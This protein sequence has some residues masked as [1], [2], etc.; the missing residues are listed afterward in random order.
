MRIET[1]VWCVVG[2]CAFTLRPGTPVFAADEST[3]PTT[4]PAS[5][6][7]SADASSG[8]TAGT[9]AV[10]PADGA[11]VD[12]PIRFSFKGATFEQV[13]DFFS[14]TTG[15][16]V[17]WQTA[18][19]G[20]TL[21]YISPESY[22]QDEALSVL[23]II[24]Q[25]KGVMLRLDRGMLYLQKMAEMQREDVPTFVGSLPDSVRPEEVVTIVRPLNIAS[26]TVL[27]ERLGAM[28]AAYG[29]VVAVPQQNALVITETAAQ[30][31]RLAL[32]IDELDRGDPDG[33]VHIIQLRHIRATDAMGALT[34]LLGQRV[35]RYVINEKG[36]QRKIEEDTMPG[37]NITPDVRTNALIARG[38]AARIQQLRDAVLL[39]DVPA[40][41]GGRGMRSFTLSR[42]APS[43][44]IQRIQPVFAQLPAPERPIFVPVDEFA[45]LT[46]I[47]ADAQIEEVVR[48]LE[49][50]D[51]VLPGDAA[52]EDRTVRIVPVHDADAAV[53]ARTLPTLLS[54]RQQGVLSVAA[55][56]DGRSIVL[57]GPR[58]DV[59]HAA[60]IVP[61]LD[62]T[63]PGARE[64]RLV[65]LSGPDP[66]AAVARTAALFD[67][68]NT[69][70][71]T[72]TTS[73]TARLDGD[74][75]TLTLVGAR[76]PMERWLAL[77]RTVQESARAERETRQIDVRH[78][79]PSR[80][81]PRLRE[82]AG[83]LLRSV[84]EPGGVG[85]DGA[86][87][88]PPEFD[89]I[90][91]L[92]VVVVTAVPSEMSA[93]RSLVQALDRVEAVDLAFRVVSVAGVS[94]PQLLLERTEAVAER[95][96]Q[97]LG[98]DA[99]AAPQVEL[100]GLTSNVL[101]SGRAESVSLWE[102]ALAEARRLLPPSRSLEFIAVQHRRASE[103]VTPL[104]DLATR[105]ISVD[106]TRMEPQPRIEADERTNNLLV[107]AEP[108]QHEVIRRL[109]RELDA[110]EP[111]DLPPLRMLQVR[112]A[113]VNRLGD[114]LR[115]RY[116]ARPPE[117]RRADPV[118]IVP[119][120]GTST[121]VV[122]AGDAVFQEIRAFI[123][124]INRADEA[125]TER[126]TMIFALRRA[127][128]ADLASAL[129]RLYP[130]PP[131]PL[132]RAGRPLPH[133]RPPREVYVTADPGTNTLIVEAPPQ[134]RASFESLVDQLDRVELPPRAT[135]RTYRIERGDPQHIA[136]TLTDLAR[137]GVLAEQPADGSKP[138]EVLVRAETTS[139]TL[140]VAGDEVTFTQVERM[141]SDLE[142]V[143]VRRTLR[144][145][146]LATGDPREIAERAQRLYREQTEGER[147]TGPVTVEVDGAR[148]ALLVVA[149]DEAMV[150]FARIID[151]LEQA[152][153]VPPE[154]ELV[155]LEHAEAEEA[156]VFLRDLAKSH[157]ALTGLRGPEP[158]F[159]AIERT[160]SVL[161]AARRDQREIVR[162]I[163]RGIDRP[164]ARMMPPLRIMQLRT[165][166]A[167]ALASAL[168]RKYGARSPEDRAERPADISADASTNSLLVAAH[169]EIAEE[170]EGIVRQLNDADRFGSAERVIRIFSLRVARAEEL[171]R[172]LDEMFPEPP[173][174][175]DARGRPMPNLRPQREV[176]VRADSQTNSIIVDAPGARMSGFEQLVEQLDRARIA[177]ETEIRTYA[178]QHADPQQ[179]A[180]TIRSLAQ[181]G[182]LAPAAADRRTPITVTADGASRTIVVS[183]PRDV[184]ERVTRVI[185]DLD[186]RPALPMVAV[187]FFR[188]EHARAESL[189]EMLRGI[190]ATRLAQ[191]LPAGATQPEAL[192]QVTADRKT[193]TLIV[194]APTE[195]LELAELLVKQL[196]TARAAHSDT[197]V[198]VRSLTFADAAS[199]VQSVQSAL[200]G[201][202]SR[203]TGDAFDV[204]LI[205]APG[206]N[207]I[208]MVGTDG[209][210]S[211]IDA[212]IEPLDARPATDA[213]DART[214]RLA[215]ANAGEIAG[216]VQRL[217]VDQQASDPRFVLERLRRSRGQVDWIPPIR[218]EA[219]WR[220]NS[221]I[222]S[223]PATTV[224]LAESLVLTLDQADDSA[225]R[226]IRTFTPKRGDPVRLAALVRR[227]LET[228]RKGGRPSAL[229]LVAE[230]Q[231]RAVLVVGAEADVAQAMALLD[232]RD[233]EWVAPPPMAMR[234]I[235][236]EHGSAQT[237]AETIRP[238][239]V[240]PSR[241][242]QSM[243]D[244]VAAGLTVAQPS[245][246]AEPG[247]QRILIAAPEPLLPLAEQLIAGLDR[248]RVE[249]AVETRV[250]TLSRAEAE[251]V[252]PVVRSAL[253]AI[254]RT[255]P[256]APEP[257]VS[258]ETS[259]NA[260][261]VTAAPGMLE[262]IER[263][264]GRFDEGVGAID[265]PQVRTIPLTKA[266]AETVATIVKDVL[267]RPEASDAF[268]IFGRPR[269]G[270]AIDDRRSEVRVAAD[271]RLNA[272]VVS[273]PPPTL[274]MIEELVRRLD[275]D[276]RADEG[277]MVHV[278]T[279]ENADADEVL[280]A[281]TD[282]FAGAEDGGS[283]PILRSDRTSN[284]LLIRATAAQFD[285]IREVALAIDRA[286]VSASREMRLIQIDPSRADAA[287]VARAL[288]RLLG[289]GGSAVEVM[290]LEELLRRRS[291]DGAPA[292]ARGT[293][294][295]ASG[296]SDASGA[297]RGPRDVEAPSPIRLLLP[298]AGDP[299]TMLA[300][301]VRAGAMTLALDDAGDDDRAER[302]APRDPDFF[303]LSR[304]RF[305]PPAPARP[306]ARSPS[307]FAPSP[308]LPVAPSAAPDATHSGG[309]DRAD[310]DDEA[311]DETGDDGDDGGPPPP[312]PS[313]RPGARDGAAAVATPGSA[314]PPVAALPAAT[315]G[316]DRGDGA[317]LAIAVDPATNSIIIIG[318]T[319]TL[320]R[321]EA[322]ARRLE[323]QLPAPADGVRSIVLP[324]ELS[325]R[326]M[327]Q[328]LQST[329][330]RLRPAGGARGDLARRVSVFPD[331]GS[332]SLVI[333]CADRDLPL[334]ADLVGAFSRA[335]AM[336]E[337]VIKVYALRTVTAERAMRTVRGLLELDGPARRGRQAERMRPLAL[338]ILGGETEF[339]AALSPDRVQ[340]ISET[341]S[342]QLLVAAPPEAIP[343]LDRF[344]ELIDQTPS[345]TVATL[346][347]FPLRHARA[348][349]LRGTF[350][351]L[352]RAR[353]R[354]LRD[355]T[356]TR[357][358][359]P[360]FVA[361]DRTNMLLVTAS[362][363]QL[364][365]VADL[366]TRLDVDPIGEAHPLRI[367]RLTSML[368]T[369]AASLLTRTV[370][371]EDQQRRS[372]ALILGDDAAGVLLVRADPD[373]SAEIDR[374]LA[375]LDRDAASDL[376][377]RTVTLRRAD[378]GSLA[379]ALQ[380]FFDDRARIAS[381]GR[382]R[383]E[384]AR[385][386][387]IVGDQNSRT[388]VIAADD[389]DFGEIE[390]LVAQFDSVE[391]AS[392][393]TYRIFPLRHARATEISQSVSDLIDSMIW[394]QGPFFF[395]DGRM[396]GG[397]RG[398]RGAVAVQADDR[399][400]ALI[401]TGEG[402]RFDLVAQIVETLDAPATADAQRTV[403]LYRVRA[404]RAD[405]V[406]ET[407]R[408]VFTDDRA[409][410]RWWD[411]AP[412][413]QGVRISAD[414]KSGTIVVVATE[415]E[416]EDIADFIARLDEGPVLPERESAVIAVEF[417]PVREVAQSIERF[418]RERGEVTATGEAPPTIV[419]AETAGALLVAASPDT[420]ALV[421]DLVGRLDQP[422]PTGERGVEIVALRKGDPIEIGRIVREQFGGRTGG[423]LTV[424][425]DARTGSLIMSAPRRQLAAALAL[426]EQLDGRAA[427]DE[428]I[429]RTYTLTGAQATDAVRILT[430]TLSLD[431]R[432]RTTGAIVRLDDAAEPVEVRARIT[433]DR[434]SNSIVVAATSES[435][436][437]IE[438]LIRQLEDVPA[439]A[440]V[441]YRIIR[442]AHAMADDL[443]ITLR[444]IGGL[445]R[446]GMPSPSFDYNRLE[447]QLIVAAT[448]DQFEQIERIIA[449]VDVPS[450]RRRTTDFVPLRFAEADKIQA[451]LSVFY[452]PFAFEADT[453]GKRTVRIVADQATNSLVISAD[454]DEWENIRALLTRLDN[455]EYD[456]SL[457]LRVLPLLHADSRSVARAINEAFA[458]EMQAAGRARAPRQGQPAAAPREG[459]RGEGQEAQ[460]QQVLIEA[461]EWVRASAEPLTNSVVVSASRPNIR[462][463]E[464][465]VRQIDVADY[466][467][468]PPVRIIP[469]TTG[470]P[471]SIAQAIARLYAD[472]ESAGGRKALR[473]VGDRV[474][475]S[476]IVRVEESE[477]AQ[478]AALAAA[479]QE[480]TG[481]RGVGVEVMRMA[482]APAR[483]VADAIR[484]AYQ[485]KATELRT[486]LS[487]QVDAGLN[488]IVVATTPELSR[489]IR[490]TAETLDALAPGAGQAV[491]IIELQHV[492]P[493]A[494]KSFIESI[495]LDRPAPADSAARLVSEPVRVA[496]LAG[497]RAIAVVAN[498]ADRE[499]I[500]QALKAIDAEPALAEM[501][502]RIHRLRYAQASA[503]VT[504][505]QGMF[506]PADQQVQTP[507]AAAVREQVRRLSV[508]RNGLNDQDLALD[509]TTP[510]RLLADTTG[511]GVVVVSTPENVSAVIELVRLLDG[512]PITDAVA[513]QIFPLENIAAPQF[514]R[515]VRDL[516]DQGKRLARVPG[517]PLTAVPGGV[518]GRA[519]VDELA[520]TVD[521]RTNTVIAAGR[522]E[523]VAFVDVLRQ[524]LD[525][526][527]AAGWLEPRLVPLVHADA[528]TLAETLDAILVRGV[529][530]LPQSS[531][532][533][534]QIGRLRVRDGA[535]GGPVDSGLFQPMTRLVIRAEPALKAIVLVGTPAN[536]EAVGALIRMLDVE[537]AAPGALVRT[538]PIRNGSAAR[539]APIVEQI[540]A[541]QIRSRALREEDRLTVQADERTNSIIVSTSPRA[542]A[543]LEALLPTL[544]AEVPPELREL[545]TMSL[546]FASAS[547]LAAT[548][549][550]LMDARVDR[551]RR[552]RPETADLERVLVVPD[553][554]TNALVISA[555]NEAYEVIT[556]LV[557]E[558]DTATFADASGVEVIPVET[559]NVDRVA[560][561]ID[562]IMTRRYSELPPEIRTTQKPLVLVDPRTNSLL[563]AANPEDLESIRSLVAKL[564][565][566]PTD[567]AVGVHV[568]TLP[569]NANATELAPR[570]QRLMRERIQSLG[571]ARR[572]SDSITIEP[573]QRGNALIVASSRE[574]L[575]IVEGL[576]QVLIEAGAQVESGRTFDI[577]Q[578]ALNRADVI[579]DLLNEIHVRDVNEKRG[580]R[581]VQVTA[582][583][584]SNSILVS[585]PQDEIR[586]IRDLVAQLDGVKP[587][588]VVE[589]RSIPLQSANALETVG[590]VNS[591]LLGRGQGAR[592]GAGPAQV[593]RYAG[594]REDGAGDVELTSAIRDSITLTPDVR[595]NT[596]IVSAP[597][598]AM[599]MI[600]RMIR[601]LDQSSTGAKSIRVFR[602]ENADAIATR[603]ILIDLFNLRQGRELLVLKPR[604]GAA[605]PAPGAP[606]LE[607]GAPAGPAPSL[608]GGELTAVP[609]ERQQLSITVDSRTNSL[610]VSGTP[611][612]LD[613][614]SE[615]VS[616]LD[617]REANE[618]EV[619]VY[620]LRNAGAENVA[621][622]LTD[623]VQ[624]EQR[625]MVQTLSSDQLG[626]AARILEREITVRGDEKSNSVLISAS[627]RY[628]ETVKRMLMQ[629]DIDPPQVL[630]QVMLA[631]VTLDGESEYGLDMAGNFMVGASTVTGGFGFAT[632]FV[633][634]LGVPNLSV[635]NKDFSLLLRAMES[636]GRLQVLS[637]PSIMA[638]NNEPAVLQVGE[639]IRVPDRTSFTDSGNTNTITVEKELGI[640]LNVTPSINPDGFVRMTVEPRIEN[641]T[642]RTTQINENLESPVITVR[643]ASTTV[644]VHD[645]Q[646]IVIG[647]LISDRFER[648]ERKVPFLGDLPLVGLLFRSEREQ[649]T[650]TEF[651]IVLTPHVISSPSEFDRVSEL[652][653]RETD[654]LTLPERLRELI[655]EGRFDLG[656]GIFDSNGRPILL[657]G[658]PADGAPAGGGR[659]D[660]RS[661]RP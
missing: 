426:V 147:A 631:E 625:R 544:D 432:G 410:R 69:G 167:E 41:G 129:E 531:P 471:E 510:I 564:E 336:E 654:R 646:T 8:A 73:M 61:A 140:I 335:P 500:V 418:L 207:A 268:L 308:A 464:E 174:P 251:R 3:A 479:M 226:L 404:M 264:V 270:Q 591:V 519:L 484:A 88:A 459:A 379:T 633:S 160:N 478:I 143:P 428:T 338:R 285:R 374:V 247:G 472:G 63:A 504:L 595:T 403:R 360:E 148:G 312:A 413:R 16:P 489:E 34:S 331:D 133:L 388:L 27:A 434:R 180:T 344:I 121:L 198:R 145:F 58:S 618:R 616:E 211:E 659:S 451:A 396:S 177:D 183:G 76:E 45:R 553:A 40:T 608:L 457:Q 560:Q 296:R 98:A 244:V 611:A 139:R 301:L 520:L 522:E 25:S 381:S 159:E 120:S 523:A 176:V 390:R 53:V 146:E 493:D 92:R 584:R 580:A 282:L 409:Q 229:E 356:G 274:E 440:P 577:I 142:A 377:I 100:D 278:L 60:L 473:I 610:L 97:A 353:V 210:L 423:G 444:S 287:D 90:D 447:N 104:S 391:S 568:V 168:G 105:A 260:V 540:F 124:E 452:G 184:F 112:A 294:A 407:L 21:D 372:R 214:F 70:D 370:L 554:R 581:T 416:Q 223:G 558:L 512:L 333:T 530:T 406:A 252:A 386:V 351:D 50:A 621:R 548:V 598:L 237:I 513:V 171:A 216:T 516:V 313:G 187:R 446:D 38:T 86:D 592:R 475:G 541:G 197:V 134:R 345:E 454:E 249:S 114:L 178:V 72:P 257:S 438:A 130:D 433:A 182:S 600:E 155:T 208:I 288:E 626:S 283:A 492:S 250:F 13:I 123:E 246:T 23:N 543:I 199:I 68:A 417:A 596:V 389:R 314:A 163:L 619:F 599:P 547:R 620:Q 35:E 166:D 490:Q 39:L 563:V 310:A 412:A 217:L 578:V 392:E 387:S 231:S 215:H 431:P 645:G 49:E 536:L 28:V 614:V 437:V 74:G 551:I 397:S 316:A 367:V 132:D 601:D 660:A 115:Q 469:V 378:A 31:R 326:S 546:R 19:P 286:T 101:V 107:L 572:P 509:L 622:V 137:Q 99:P 637:N 206:A 309:V 565:Q 502:M 44:A 212:L 393:W 273:A 262:E 125:G 225:T 37:L 196:D 156:V 579:V 304:V 83:P 230:A 265:R 189:A 190:L 358:M 511:N 441:E 571:P 442:L 1:V 116:D 306:G 639:T 609:D 24:L 634:G 144:V 394:G 557:S 476:I 341:E 514:A 290:T 474:S 150:R 525:S 224:S 570:I 275:A 18:A 398:N 349:E 466:A 71:P 485:L 75:R 605:M 376:P 89:P 272:I 228:A 131:M 220:T 91:A 648:R 481:T 81:V 343:V 542:F 79:P 566:V 77:L 194:Q 271:P 369:S 456:A 94:S 632:A 430:E 501:Q 445:A 202:A 54:R 254:R 227:A 303:P 311:D 267:A 463:I 280:R 587:A 113:D 84:R 465:I 213:L 302:G 289:R 650:K 65:R 111:R 245:I 236:V 373:V 169:P 192:L 427:G 11:I 7:S 329:L 368:P 191:D 339:A 67:L 119:D 534:Q 635:A 219:D 181:A 149:E 559:G 279:L 527:V 276:G 186:V 205:A 269:G 455:E 420:L 342:N 503:V 552:V 395:M 46:V 593:L 371:G 363:E 109:V 497:R 293:A 4:P 354:G 347:F 352:F 334:V 590:L 195:I 649:S 29:S 9:P 488:A 421:R 515:I 408:G 82:L 602:L 365:E 624:E 617:S 5:G 348:T 499:T 263:L 569:P 136:Q 284:A 582:D 537:E 161:V 239:L 487:I 606:G 22:T 450:E 232:E 36:Q 346:R 402:D 361:D 255:M 658:E 436:P 315:D 505:L 164:E 350:A 323:A 524:R 78:V 12:R 583:E 172:T 415:R 642:Q 448:A 528:V 385:R 20:G 364:A 52:P 429:I 258:A 556:R 33:E 366:L 498:P 414:T 322:L 328:V 538:Y 234:I 507:L 117:Q 14:R 613:L 641:L 337:R 138:V 453:P 95:M 152:A 209:E 297:D 627:P 461:T 162:A 108:A 628:M 549:Q 506:N 435:L 615:V 170:V 17:I 102:R 586:T 317:A 55:G 110:P 384:Q 291:S 539:L 597:G 603:E 630:I 240:D 6:S 221:L 103:L 193:N 154:L 355:Q 443:A 535:G 325:A 26:A 561:A 517:T 585:G 400:N 320:E 106:G 10:P 604:E 242:P 32:I 656:D 526:D 405:L 243:R 574:N 411:P 425:P 508:R 203:N 93:I 332:N 43:Q 638:A 529:Q 59:E 532:L 51:G 57:A 449:Q 491:F 575:E 48:L 158:R 380:R 629:L 458:G 521:E 318:G 259:S 661:D 201:L 419:A 179:V 470:D 643:R 235:R 357:S 330:E 576:V 652:T 122:T 462:K 382:G 175:V 157:L 128:A 42:L 383:R 324:P 375:E 401:V 439:A 486:P 468:L 340:V 66:A 460:P 2:S 562:Q 80:L 545:R 300:M 477:Y 550:S 636:Q 64:V 612:Y 153:G 256:G 555:G 327:A 261:V 241:W 362:P 422:D 248:G 533:Q 253:D 233:A 482:Q 467:K 218:V 30:V 135:L 126:T 281:V 623:F 573:E 298:G 118:T 495:G 359:D 305:D 127:R 165:A 588:T 655:R 87:A 47:G 567:P 62:R 85:A 185:E 141:L 307:A 589:V 607:G 15:L 299:A 657:D 399:L 292:D 277:R 222:V 96:R 483:R 496:L 204:R 424:T 200:A 188:L 480:Q 640:V 173:V 321:A 151:Q 594:P 238:I 647:G 266:R 653:A 295:P 319:R 494:A 651:L 644:T 518:V 56:A